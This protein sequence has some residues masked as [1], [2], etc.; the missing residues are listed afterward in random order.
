[1]RPTAILIAAILA[2]PAAAAETDWQEV[3]PD[4][5]MRLVADPVGTVPGKVLAALQIDMP[6]SHNTYWRIPGEAGIAPELD[7]SGSTGLADA[8]IRFPLPVADMSTGYLDYIYPG[9]TALPVELVVTDAGAVLEASFFL[10]VCHDVCMPVSVDFTLPLGDEPLSRD[11]SETVA[12]AFARVPET[13]VFADPPIASVTEVPGGVIVVP[14]Y[15]GIAAGSLVLASPS[16]KPLFGPATVY[17]DGSAM[18]PVRGKAALPDTVEVSF[19]SD[20]GVYSVTVPVSP[21]GASTL[22]NV[23]TSSSSLPSD[24]TASSPSP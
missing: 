16:G 1:M 8:A 2:A 13:W 7:W 12:S 19:D 22:A 18:L 17:G 11:V 6:D 24:T 10:G 3:V 15:D 14:A 9:P 4:V 23:S 21:V 5:R 20:M